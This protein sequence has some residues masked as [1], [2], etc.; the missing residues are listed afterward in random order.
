MA[1]V[2]DFVGGR[3]LVQVNVP[4][5]VEPLS[6]W[7]GALRAKILQNCAPFDLSAPPAWPTPLYERFK[8]GM[9][10]YELDTPA[11]KEVVNNNLSAIA[12]CFV[13]NVP[14]KK[15]LD[16][17]SVEIETTKKVSSDDFGC[18][19][20]MLFFTVETECMTR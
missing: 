16:W 6:A 9:S 14:L 5:S 4:D 13:R 19:Q 20:T 2:A 3:I 7:S 8:L 10:L 12:E 15:W 11:G 1:T 17:A 18:V